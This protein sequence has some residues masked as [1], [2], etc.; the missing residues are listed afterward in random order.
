MAIVLTLR[1]VLERAVEKEIA[2]Q[3]LYT[4]LCVKTRDPE[5][6]NVLLEMARQEKG[7]ERLLEEYMAGKIKTG[8]LNPGMVVD[9]K[10]AETLE[11]PEEPPA[12]ALKDIFLMAARREK[13][14]HELYLGLARLHPEGEV[15]RTL[16]DL[17]AQ[18]LQ[19]KLRVETL[20]TEV[21]FP[22]TD[23]G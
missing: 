7:H 13:A 20:Y 22:Q 10:I 8:T 15:C 17:A 23:G 19:H 9:Y 11:E 18:E 21:A 16:N 14:A 6:R 2:S 4:E 12:M 1:Q 3:R 5:V